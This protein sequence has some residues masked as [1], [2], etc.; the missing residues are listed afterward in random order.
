MTDAEVLADSA[1]RPALGKKHTRPRPAQFE[2][3]VG[4]MLARAA[5]GP[6]DQM[7]LTR[8]GRRRL[9]GLSRGVRE[10]ACRARHSLMFARG[11][12]GRRRDP[13]ERFGEAS[14]AIVGHAASVRLCGHLILPTATDHQSNNSCALR[15]AILA[16]PSD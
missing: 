11:V 7:Q 6:D 14:L 16:S 15:M 3:L 2:N 12:L 9:A 13:V 5:H 8:L 1:H 10:I 4:E